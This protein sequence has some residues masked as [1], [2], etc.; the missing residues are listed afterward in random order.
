METLEIKIGQEQW[1]ENKA[2]KPHAWKIIRKINAHNSEVQDNNGFLKILKSPRYH[3]CANHEY[4]ICD[5]NN[6][7]SN[8]CII[9]N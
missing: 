2:K 9:E 7:N 4:I 1:P 5:Y 8:S 6:Q 3:K